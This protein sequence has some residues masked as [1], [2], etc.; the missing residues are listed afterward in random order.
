MNIALIKTG[1][2]GDVVRTTALV[3][4]LRR[5]FPDVEITWI[6]SSAAL[7]LV[8]GLP[9]VRAVAIEDA[10]DA[11]WRDA[12][13]RWIIS[14]DDEYASC[15][16]ATL[17]RGE[18]VSGAHLDSCGRRTYTQDLEGWFGMGVLRPDTLGGLAIANRLKRQNPRSY[19]ELLYKGLGLP[20]PVARPLVIVPENSRRDAAEWL[21][22]Q[23]IARGAAL[24]GVNTGSSGRWR[25][26]TWGIDAT[27]SLARRLATQGRTVLVL[28]GLAERERNAAICERARHARVVAGPADFDLL[29]F[30]ALVGA[31]TALVSSDTLAMHL[32]IAACVPVVALFGPTSSAEI[33]LLG[34]GEKVVAPVPCV[35]CF[36]STCDVSP[37]CM[38]AITPERVFTCV[39]RSH[40]SGLLGEAPGGRY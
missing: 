15:Q 34:G 5:R 28:G 10:H 29:S 1:A 30:A 11:S 31:C 33:D 9:A 4:G 8:A 14:L 25:H 6:T 36:R 16:T 17:L 7:P 19:G 27:A 12:R 3:V 24:V 20:L 22:A 38:Q 2:L 26:K 13:Y 40:G 35:R 23:G 18:R 37:N 21:E 32:A 39:L